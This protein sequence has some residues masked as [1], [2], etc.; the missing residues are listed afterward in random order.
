MNLTPKM[1]LAAVAVL[2]G[3]VAMLLLIGPSRSGRK[4]VVYTSVDTEFAVPLFEKFKKETGIEV[5]PNFSDEASKTTEMADRLL[6]L[7]DNPDGDVFWNSELSFTQVL[8]ARGVLDKYDSPQAKDIPA[9]YRDTNGLWT[10]FGCRCRVLLYNTGLVKKEEIPHTLED[11]ADPRWRGKFTVAKPLY[12]TTRSHLVS[13][14]VALGEEKAF[15][16]FRAWRENGLVLAESNSDVR[17]RV[18][19]GRSEI[20]LT[21]T[22]D[23]YSAIDRHKPVDFFIFDQTRDW[24]GAY[25]V[26]N[27]VSILNKCPHPAEAKAFED[28]LLRRDTEAWLA[29][30]DARQI[31]VRD[32][33]SKLPDRLR[34]LKTAKVDMQKVSDEVLPMGERIYRILLGEEK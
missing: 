7:K 13:L 28:F 18:A 5:V 8:A 34:G 10:G 20:G 31:P 23:A 12:G 3:V 11:L 17:E 2:C 16:L 19:D 27:T 15:K 32:V 9:E 29:D 1:L 4:V 14:V 33:T 30:Q 6:R 24:P 21:D 22:D 26:P 25:L